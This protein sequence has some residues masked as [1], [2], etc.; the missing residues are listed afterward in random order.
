MSHYDG[1]E[2]I[3][4]GG[5]TDQSIASVA[6]AVA[7]VVGYRGRLRFDV[8]KPDG[9]PFKRLD[10]R[11]LRRLGWRP[12]TDFRTALAATYAWFLCHTVKEDSTDVRAAV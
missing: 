7:E 10:C 4:L 5:G 2:P 9:M 12:S 11:R 8:D 3:N 6:R 1:L